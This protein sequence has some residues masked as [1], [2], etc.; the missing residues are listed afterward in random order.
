M[1]ENR[2]SHFSRNRPA[3]AVRKILHTTET[4]KTSICSYTF[5]LS[6]K[7]SQLTEDSAFQ[8]I[9]SLWM[10]KPPAD[11]SSEYPHTCQ[12]PLT[13][14]K[15]ERP[16]FRSLVP[17]LELCIEMSLT[18]LS[19][20]R[21]TSR[22]S[23]SFFSTKEVKF[24]VCKTRLWFQ[25]SPRSLPLPGSCFIFMSYYFFYQNTQWVIEMCWQISC[26]YIHLYLCHWLIILCGLNFMWI[27]ALKNF[28]WIEC[29][30]PHFH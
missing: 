28:K 19:W 22:T 23:S 13:L 24:N 29:C 30:F 16:L 2:D 11:L 5:N 7:N 1:E 8:S 4:C 3:L 27:A 17:E 20:Y 12:V 10:L 21:S 9:L 26:H 25:I 18:I 14:V 15:E 6:L